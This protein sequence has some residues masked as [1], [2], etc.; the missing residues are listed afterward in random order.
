MI[1]TGSG[2]TQKARAYQ[3]QGKKAEQ[4]GTERIH[5]I[6]QLNAHFRHKTAPS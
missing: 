1:D 5:D 3:N 2:K 6:L 4:N